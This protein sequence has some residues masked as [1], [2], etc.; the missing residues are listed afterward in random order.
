LISSPTWSKG[1]T[2]T[3]AGYSILFN[4]TQYVNVGSPTNLGLSGNQ[5]FTLSAWVNPTATTNNGMI[6]S[7]GG[8]FANRVISIGFY[9]TLGTVFSV[10][11]GDDHSYSYKAPFNT[12][13]LLTITYDGTTEKLYANGTFQSSWNPSF[14]LALQSGDPLSIARSSWTP[15]DM[16]QGF[17]S[18]VRIYNEALT[19]DGVNALYALSAPRYKIALK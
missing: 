18:E 17:V 7:Y 12:W 13:T 9:D 2:P 14:P 6:V 5:P 1:N 8:P 3:G 11:Y 19:A 16:A 10:H 4:G 15:T